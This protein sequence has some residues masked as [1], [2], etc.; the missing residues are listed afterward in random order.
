MYFHLFARFII[1]AKLQCTPQRVHGFSR[2]VS[3][4]TIVLENETPRDFSFLYSVRIW[5][6]LS[7][8][9]VLLC[10][11]F[12]VKNTI[13]FNRVRQAILVHLDQTV[14]MVLTVRR[15]MLVSKDSKVHLDQRYVFESF[16]RISPLVELEFF[17][18]AARLYIEYRT[19]TYNTRPD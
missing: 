14:K 19:L 10:S 16:N 2:I 4:F 6:L 11:L 13:F 3:M 15:V 9:F 18:P 12:P 1:F 8:K 17:N 7:G 5:N